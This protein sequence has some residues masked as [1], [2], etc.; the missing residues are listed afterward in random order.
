[1]GNQDFVIYHL[2]EALESG[3]AELTGDETRAKRLRALTKLRLISMSDNE[4]W[5]LSSITS[6]PPA[7]SVEMAYRGHKSTVERL[8]ATANQWLKDL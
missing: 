2:V 8:S 1:L 3:L 4:L 6:C 7:R 5:E